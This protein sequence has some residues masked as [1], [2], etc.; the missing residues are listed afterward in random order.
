MLL[1]Q[2]QDEGLPFEKHSN[3]R[4][5]QIEHDAT[6]CY[7]STLPLIAPCRAFWRPS[8]CRVSPTTVRGSVSHTNLLISTFSLVLQKEGTRCGHTGIVGATGYKNTNPAS[9]F[10]TMKTMLPS[11]LDE[12]TCIRLKNFEIDPATVTWHS[13]SQDDHKYD[14]QSKTTLQNVFSMCMRRLVRQRYASQLFESKLQWFNQSVILHPHILLWL[15][16]HHGEGRGDNAKCETVR[17]LQTGLWL[18]WM[19]RTSHSEL[20]AVPLCSLELQGWMIFPSKHTTRTH[21]HRRWGTCEWLGT[22][23]RRADFGVS[24]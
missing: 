5:M 23:D 8:T 9:L 18:I 16:K 17:H 24:L 13:W 1:S 22:A 21:A 20:N 3:L 19:A 10:L 6:S 2:P 11:T 12:P 4:R 14:L 15:I 7:H